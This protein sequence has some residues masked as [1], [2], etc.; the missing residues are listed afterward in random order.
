MSENLNLNYN[1][2]NTIIKAIK[3]TKNNLE[4][5]EKLGVTER[6]FYNL[7]KEH[8]LKE[9]KR[10]VIPLK[11][12]EGYIILTGEPDPNWIMALNKMVEL[13]FKNC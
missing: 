2:K 5:A 6:T 3:I 12:V 9:F 10:T 8:G 4:A 13:A 1:I 7:L 11:N